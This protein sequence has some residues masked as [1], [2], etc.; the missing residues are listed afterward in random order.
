MAY[1]A[2]YVF[3]SLDAFEGVTKSVKIRTPRDTFST[4]RVYAFVARGRGDERVRGEAGRE[5][6][7]ARMR[8]WTARCDLRR[9][10]SSKSCGRC[11]PI[12]ALGT[13]RGESVSPR[14]PLKLIQ[15]WACSR[16]AEGLRRR[17]R[18]EWRKRHHAQMCARW[19]STRRGSSSSTG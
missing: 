15:L 16:Q 9:A 11:A 10:W 2:L 18:A 7:S 4:V 19:D 5:R 3:G 13:S 8:D 1:T 6:E 12:G 17:S 14:E